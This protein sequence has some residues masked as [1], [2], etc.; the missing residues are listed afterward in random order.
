MKKHC[1][2]SYRGPFSLLAVLLLLLAGAYSAF[3]LREAESQTLVFGNIS[4]FAWS[5]TI[6]WI[7][8]N[9]LNPGN[10]NSC[11]E[12]SWGV[13]ATGEN[14]PE[15]VNGLQSA[16][17]NADGTA[18]PGLLTGYAWSDN[19]GWISFGCGQAEGSTGRKQCS[20]NSSSP[21][22]PTVPG[23]SGAHGAKLVS[24]A[25]AGWAR[26]CSVFQSGCS[27]TLKTSDKTGNWDGWISLSGSVVS[28]VSGAYGVQLSGTQFSSY[29]WGNQVVGWVDFH[30]KC[31]GTTTFCGPGVY[32][33]YPEVSVSCTVEPGG[34]MGAIW[35][36]TTGG[37]AGNFTYRWFE[38]F[39]I[40]TSEA[41]DTNNGAYEEV[42]SD[43]SST[44]TTGALAPGYYSRYVLATETATGLEYRS[45]ACVGPN[46]TGITIRETG[47]NFILSSEEQMEVD[48][49]AG[50]G[51]AEASTT[52]AHVI[53]ESDLSNRDLA[54]TSV[55]FSADVDSAV[56]SVGSSGASA[57]VWRGLS[58][59][60]QVLRALERLAT[61]GNNN[62]SGAK[63]RV[64]VSNSGG[65]AAVCFK[66]RDDSSDKSCSP[67]TRVKSKT[68]TQNEI[69][70][71]GE[72]T[73]HCRANIPCYP[74]IP[75]TMSVKD[76]VRSGTYPVTVT[77]SGGGLTKT[78]QVMLVVN[79]LGSSVEEF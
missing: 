67:R 64:P 25:L 17:L 31:V 56:T 72:E 78:T 32:V 12:A 18:P 49:I 62:V 19:I 36:A 47:P 4:G 27:G 75:L 43:T 74:K 10:V 42:S 33:G 39:E 46:G 13:A 66:L 35:R 44:I 61:V 45:P 16:K 52:V 57:S 76:N 3:T 22:Y 5:D 50:D 20:L 8:F 28:P 48:F 14:A 6:G 73:R 24:G 21:S 58:Q 37:G 71:G 70:S 30:P 41:D 7:S 11:N 51:S 1:R 65:D 77:V 15:N 29:A 26:A 2:P 59:L 63:A 69:D 54:D 9:C 60:S 23:G 38:A 53:V 55:I 68:L 79:S 34:T 40:S